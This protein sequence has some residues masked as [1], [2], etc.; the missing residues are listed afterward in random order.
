MI[1]WNEDQLDIPLLSA[2]KAYALER[3]EQYA[4][5]YV[6][7]TKAYVGMKDDP[8]FLDKFA[9]FLLDEGKREEAIEVVKTLVLLEQSEEWTAFLEAL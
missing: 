3:E 1:L 4:H 5:A 2:F 6:S 8:A 7:Y 9:R